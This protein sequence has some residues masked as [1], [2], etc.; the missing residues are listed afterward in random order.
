MQTYMLSNILITDRWSKVNEFDVYTIIIDQQVQGSNNGK[1]A[2]RSR[3]L[4]WP[5][6]TGEGSRDEHLSR[7]GPQSKG[8]RS[9]CIAYLGNTGQQDARWEEKRGVMLELW[10]PAL[11][12]TTYLSI[13]AGCT[14]FYGHPVPDGVASSNRIMHPAAKQKASR[15]GSRQRVAQQVA[16]L[17][18]KFLT[19]QSNWESL[20]CAG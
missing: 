9:R 1:L 8:K 3:C 12:R 17:A 19:T 18:S 6:S 4:W 13:A 11:T 16:D 14:L 5:L 15:N 10:M 2:P 20:G 7:T